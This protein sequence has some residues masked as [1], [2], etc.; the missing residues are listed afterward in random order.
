M[1]KETKVKSQE[2]NLGRIDPKERCAK[3][4]DACVRA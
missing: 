2:K 4:G 1:Y 3:L